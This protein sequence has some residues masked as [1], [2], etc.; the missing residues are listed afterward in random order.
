MNPS[1][2]IPQSSDRVYLDHNATS[3]L[4]L[5]LVEELGRW[6]RS[7]GNPSS[8]HWDGR[9]PKNLLREARQRVA[10]LVGANPLEVVFTSGGSEANNLALKGF[11]GARA[12]SEVPGERLADRS[13]FI[14]SAVEHPSVRKTV[15]Y[16]TRWG[17]QVRVIGVDRDGQ[18]DLDSYAEALKT[19]TALVSVMYANNETGTIFPI[20]KMTKMAHE[21]GAIFH[22]DAVQALGKAVV[23]VK[24]WGVDLASFS[25][26]K[27][28]GLKGAGCLYV[29]QGLQLESLIHGGGQERGRRAGTENVMAIAAMGWMAQAAD[30]IEER[31]GAM[32]ALRDE[33]EQILLARISDSRIIASP[34]KRLPNTTSIQIDGIDGETLLMNLDMAGFAVSTGAACSAGSP[35]PSPVL[36]AM[37]FS[38]KEAQSSMRLSIGWGTTRE[39]LA[40]FVETLQVTVQRLRSLRDAV[41]DEHL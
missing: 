5:G 6:S 30:Q 33:F 10:K 24:K 14:V 28:Y 19:P 4:A 18:I 36:L 17:V 12:V 9:A 38:R 40:R 41:K 13:Q 29:R 20:Q 21:A 3:P 2:F 15:D 34:G 1:P 8:I 31:A 16:L 23:D 27:F 39:E 37:G 26:H 22:C 35:E 25:A 32:K 11:H 7:W